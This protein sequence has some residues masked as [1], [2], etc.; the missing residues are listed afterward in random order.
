M[1]TALDI[2]EV[3]QAAPP[4]ERAGAWRL[5][6]FYE[7][8]K[9]RM[10]FL[11]IITT[12]VGFYMAAAVGQINWLLM[13]HTLLGTALT[14]ASASALNQLI[15]RRF[16]ALMPRTRHRPLVAGRIAP[17]EALLFGAAMGIIG[18]S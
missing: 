14:A 16:D 1:Q 17:A 4:V 11:V 8:T 2:L 5:A 13:L 9:P 7:L 18:I 10:N 3:P 12:M 6:D 15:E